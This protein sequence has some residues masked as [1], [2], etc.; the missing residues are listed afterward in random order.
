MSSFLVSQSDIS[1]SENFCH[2]TET[3]LLCVLNDLLVASNSGKTSA[4]TLDLSSAF[5]AVGHYILL[6]RLQNHFGVSG[7]FSTVNKSSTQTTFSPTQLHFILEFLWVQSLGL[8]CLRCTNNHYL[9]YYKTTTRI[10]NCLLMILNFTDPVNQ[11]TST[12]LS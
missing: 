6:H 11:L 12:R 8:F 9:R 10:T 3:A 5:D 7:S 1:L 2:S 4:L